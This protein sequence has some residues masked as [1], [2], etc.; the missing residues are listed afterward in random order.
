MGTPANLD[1]ATVASVIGQPA[2]AAMLDA[3]LGGRWLT[4]T[5][6]ARHAGV[7]PG[8][9]SDHLAALVEAHLV[10]CRKS[11]RRRYH[12]LA[13][14]QVAEALESLG[15][16]T[17]TPSIHRPCRSPQERAF[18]FART[19]Y[20]HL[21]GRLGILITD[22]MVERELLSLDGSR[23]TTDGESFLD[24]LGIDVGAL[25]ESRRSYVRLCLD[26]SERRDHVAGAV[27]AALME[28]M[29]ERR[30]IVRMEDSRAIRL[31]PRGRDQLKQWLGIPLEDTS[32][33]AL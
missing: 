9:A 25:K 7:A 6:L 24:R 14:P 32:S 11:G 19:C 4:A 17:R 3:L 10:E 5:E 12:S 31:T 18:R 8:T 26:W 20:D 33:E 2:R 15:R 1:L 21:A 23:V 13:G 27:G 22:A 16:L 30:W 29:F 28:V